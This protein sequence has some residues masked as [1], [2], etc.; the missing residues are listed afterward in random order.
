M[1]TEVLAQALCSCFTLG[2]HM[3]FAPVDLE[4]LDVSAF[5]HSWL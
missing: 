5:Y 1:S 2:L 4:G 3:S